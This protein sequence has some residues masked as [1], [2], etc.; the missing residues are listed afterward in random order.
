MTG[1]KGIGNGGSAILTRMTHP[2][3][4]T[5]PSLLASK[6]FTTLI[7]TR[8][9]YEDSDR[10]EMTPA[11]RHEPANRRL[12]VAPSSETPAPAQSN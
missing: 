2:L 10:C 5:L 7:A 12:P 8:A 1:A 11:P 4:C 3:A 6:Q 9:F